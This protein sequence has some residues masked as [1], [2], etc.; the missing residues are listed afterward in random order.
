MSLA[1]LETAIL[2]ELGRVTG[3]V[4]LKK[5]NI[6]EWATSPV[7]AQGGEV[8]AYLPDLRIHVAYTVPEQKRRAR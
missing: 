6:R 1:T 7:E 4:A 2:A 3:N 5:K 8:L